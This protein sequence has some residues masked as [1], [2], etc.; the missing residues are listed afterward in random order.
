MPTT[1]EIQVQKVYSIIESIKEASAKHDIQNVVWNWGRAY[2]YADCLRSC[3][4][5]TSGEASKLQDLAFAAQIGQ[6]KPDNKSI[7]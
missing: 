3:Q 1:K 4:L 2:S 7:R 5:I 6:V